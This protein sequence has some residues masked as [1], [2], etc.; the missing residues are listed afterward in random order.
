MDVNELGNPH[1]LLPLAAAVLI[2]VYRSLATKHKDQL[3]NAIVD[4]LDD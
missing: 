3:K 4:K 2:S 1:G